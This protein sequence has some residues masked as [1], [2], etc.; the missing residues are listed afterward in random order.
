VLPQSVR[1]E[2]EIDKSQIQDV[3][4]PLK[5]RGKKFK[6]LQRVPGA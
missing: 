5:F 1:L 3:I 4:D 6:I 2:D